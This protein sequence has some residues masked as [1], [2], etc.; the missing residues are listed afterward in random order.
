MM[1]VGAFW[2]TKPTRR[3]VTFFEIMLLRTSS[4]TATTAWSSGQV[5]TVHV[6][7]VNG[8]LGSNA[9]QK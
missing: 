2:A 1:L 4:W 8:R 3:D 7:H 5:R 6:Q 9:M